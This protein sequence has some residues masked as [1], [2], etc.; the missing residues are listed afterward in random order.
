MYFIFLGLK[1]RIMFLKNAVFSLKL[2]S[3]EVGLRCIASL[4]KCLHSTQFHCGAPPFM[5][6]ISCYW[7]E[8]EMNISLIKFNMAAIV[9]CP[10]IKKN[11]I[12]GLE[13]QTLQS[14]SPCFRLGKHL[15][16]VKCHNRPMSLQMIPV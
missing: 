10:C 5:T 12:C 1:K 2:V 11:S 13:L 4:T 14:P 15:I 8:R 6:F 7:R 9:R 3:F 16:Q